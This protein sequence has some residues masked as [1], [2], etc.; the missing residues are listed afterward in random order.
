LLILLKYVK[1]FIFFFKA[2]LYGTQIPSVDDNSFTV[3]LGFTF[4]YGGTSY[5]QVTISSNGCVCLGSL[6]NCHHLLKPSFNDIIVG[7]DYD[8]D[9]RKSGS[10]QIYYQNVAS[11]SNNFVWAQTK[12]SLA[13]PLFVAKSV[14]M[15]TYDNVMTL[16]QASTYI[17]SFQFFLL[18][19]SVSNTYVTF[20]YKSCLSGLSLL[21]PSGITFRN[22]NIATINNQCTSSNVGQ[23]GIWVFRTS[24]T[25]DT[26]SIFFIFYLEK[27]ILMMLFSLHI[28]VL[29][30]MIN[31][32]RT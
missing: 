19:D 5:S 28:L 9:T 31:L 22:G 21:S 24:K 12:V 20:S 3:N 1:T 8:L 26:F 32:F 17:A 13:N 4:I 7:L 27:L 23:T 29:E 11:G 14:F 2:A 6:T 15:I 18:S 25:T 16:N 30:T 10:G